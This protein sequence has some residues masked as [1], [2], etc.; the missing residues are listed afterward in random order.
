MVV[1]RSLDDDTGRRRLHSIADDVVDLNQMK[2][3]LRRPSF[4][5]SNESNVKCN[6]VDLSTKTYSTLDSSIDW[7]KA[8]SAIQS[9][10]SDSFKY[11]V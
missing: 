6:E 11:V 2:R 10:E 1:R 4:E 9:R 7:N 5:C 8:Y 3:A